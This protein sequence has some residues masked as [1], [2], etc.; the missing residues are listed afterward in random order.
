MKKTYSSINKSE[1][2]TGT[3]VCRIQLPFL[4]GDLDSKGFS[5]VGTDLTRLIKPSPL[6]GLISGLERDILAKK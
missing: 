5:G 3:L 4:R 2:L 6:G 1:H